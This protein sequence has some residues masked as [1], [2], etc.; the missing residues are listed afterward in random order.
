LQ[1]VFHGLR[2]QHKLKQVTL[3]HFEDAP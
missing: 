2:T 1:T 3:T